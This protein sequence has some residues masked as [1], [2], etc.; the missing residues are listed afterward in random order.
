MISR[1]IVEW[2]GAGD[3][4]K[5]RKGRENGRLV[6]RRVLA[7]SVADGGGR[8][9]SGRGEE[10][11]LNGGRGSPRGLAR[12]L[13]S[14]SWHALY[15]CSVSFGQMYPVALT[16]V[17]VRPP[18]RSPAVCQVGQA[19]GDLPALASGAVLSSLCSGCCLRGWHRLGSG[20]G[21]FRTVHRSPSGACMV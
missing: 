11:V 3:Q 2:Q 15:C 6:Q 1:C 4:D 10:S 7:G 5:M 21:W 12:M 16:C 18:Q 19:A 13:K 8:R 17:P 9:I 20:Q 14:H